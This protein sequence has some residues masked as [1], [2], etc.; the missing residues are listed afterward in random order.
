MDNK[1]EN[2]SNRVIVIKLNSENISTGEEVQQEFWAGEVKGNFQSAS[3]VWFFEH[4]GVYMD[5]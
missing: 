4:W 5:F 3:N 1:A 2:K